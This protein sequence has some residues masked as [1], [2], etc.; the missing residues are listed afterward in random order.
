MD[1]LLKENSV[2]FAEEKDERQLIAF[3]RLCH[4]VEGVSCMGRDL[5]AAVIVN[6]NLTDQRYID[7]NLRPP[8]L[9]FLK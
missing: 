6:E 8:D 1:E 7:D 5:W 2:F 9:P 4:L 3:R